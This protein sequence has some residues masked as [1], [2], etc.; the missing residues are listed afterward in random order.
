[1]VLP[2]NTESGHNGAGV[3]IQPSVA[4]VIGE[5]LANQGVKAAFGV[6]GS[7]NLVVT[8]ALCRHGV[9]FH[10]ARHEMSA[11]CMAPNRVRPVV[12]RSGRSK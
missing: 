3:T 11:L 1:M 5:T 7:G 4:D 8:N 12:I 2:A 9:Q 10:H 6:V